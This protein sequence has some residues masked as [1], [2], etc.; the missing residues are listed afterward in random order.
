[1]STKTILVADDDR[2]VRVTVANGLR[3]AGYE[4]IE[5][6]DGV[7]AVER[8]AELQPDLA[9]LDV[10]MPRMSGL[11]AARRLR[12]DA[13]VPSIILSAYDDR[14]DVERAVEEGALGYLVKP[15]D[16][17]EILPTIE[18]AIGRA[19]DISQL[20][21]SEF[22]LNRALMQGRS[23][24][25]A[26]GVLME[27][28]RLTQDEAFQ[29]LRLHARSRRQKLVEVA[30]EIVRSVESLNGVGAGPAPGRGQPEQPGE[31]VPGERRVRGE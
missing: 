29:S 6:S 18:T 5:A 1:M 2:L 25:V 16:A 28:H 26:V 9:V 17:S 23:T 4:V 14:E 11:E 10:R 21:A 31:V 20:K 7:E 8:G 13:G 30:E 3:Q 27:R 22:H 12:V 15:V 19:S 24:S